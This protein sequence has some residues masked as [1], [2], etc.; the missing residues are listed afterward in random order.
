MAGLANGAFFRYYRHMIRL[1][2]IVLIAV[3][4]AA[5]LCTAAGHENTGK[6]APPSVLR[7]LS[8]NINALPPP[9]KKHGEPLYERIA[10]ILQ[11]RRRAGDAP[12]IVLLQ[13]AF[14]KRVNVITD[15]TGYA[16]AMKGPG[17][18]ERTKTGEAHWAPQTRKSYQF[19]KNPQKLTG[20]GLYILS[21]FPLTEGQ[22]KAFDSAACA[23][24]DCLSNKAFQYANIRIPGYEPTIGILNAHLNSLNSAK[25]PSKTVYR[26][27]Q[28]QIN[29]LAGFI[30]GLNPGLPLLIGGDFNTK[31]PQRYQYFRETIPLADTAE[32]C[33]E[34][35]A[36]H[37]APETPPPM[38]L[39]GTNDKQFTR[40]FA[41]LQPIFMERNFT[42]K[43]A[44]KPLSDHLG[45][46]V[47]YRLT[48]PQD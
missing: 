31:Q 43:L 5:P 10:T 46:E 45:L 37:F 21:D 14:D 26:A 32:M 48:P 15:T 24:I 39:Y 25:A 44:G 19:Q 4:V 35:R 40:P 18:R 9:L 29:T 17:R 11:D 28:R 7:V 22:Y 23:G 33:M 38:L 6:S 34:L 27:H 12:H 20:S 13:E 8:Y 16:F 2:F 41:G 1:S 36:C 30:K 42:E 3:L 47:H